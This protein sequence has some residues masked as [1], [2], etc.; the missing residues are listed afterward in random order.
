[1][2]FLASVRTP[3]ASG[4][5]IGLASDFW[6]D[7]TPMRSAPHP[8]LLSY[9][10]SEEDRGAWVH[11]LFNR[12]A[13]HYDRLE[14][15][16][17]LGMGSWFREVSLRDAGL[18]PGMKVLDVGTGT[19]LLASAAVRIIGDASAVTAV[20]PSAPML[21][22]AKVPA[23]VSLATGSAEELPVAASCI[24]F[25]CMGYALRHISDLSAAFTE[26]HR[27][28]RPGGHV[29]I[30]EL[31]LPRRAMAR[32]ILKTWL[33]G[34]VPKIAA[35]VAPRSDAP[36]LMRY[37]WDTIAACVPP[38]TIMRTLAEAGFVGVERRVNL[39]IFS[40]YRARKPL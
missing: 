2:S 4:T 22:H 15:L 26:F 25:L 34:L 35:L 28:V 24:D 6:T 23:G 18:V 38:A 10:K 14:A 1:M 7:Q 12:T 20:D 32:M 30:L 37:Y 39:A 8:P 21:E 31:T 33:H 40:S 9:Y 27:V 36:L 13:S 3:E 19:G 16:V 11:G 29:C 5:L 17:G